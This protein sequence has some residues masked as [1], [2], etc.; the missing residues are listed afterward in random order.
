MFVGEPLVIRRRSAT[1]SCKDY[2]VF[3]ALAVATAVVVKAAVQHTLMCCS[4]D[5]TPPLVAKA[6]NRF[7]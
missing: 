3:A 4:S 1:Q 6:I 7:D 2:F 5:K